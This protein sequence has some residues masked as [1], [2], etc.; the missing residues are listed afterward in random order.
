MKTRKS[1]CEYR[2]SSSI[3]KRQQCPRCLSRDVRG[4]P[5]PCIGKRYRAFRCAAC[6]SD[7]T[8]GHRGYYG[9]M[10]DLNKGTRWKRNP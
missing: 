2:I 3:A 6:G 9:P 1:P 7:W 4:M 5:T 10:K 8:C